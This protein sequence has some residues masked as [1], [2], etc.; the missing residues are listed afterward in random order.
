MMSIV[1]TS[2]LESRVAIRRRAWADPPT[3]VIVTYSVPTLLTACR[4]AAA[5]VVPDGR[6]C[7]EQRI[8]G[9]SQRLYSAHE[10]AGKLAVSSLPSFRKRAGVKSGFGD[11]VAPRDLDTDIAKARVFQQCEVDL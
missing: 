11:S 1:C 3:T 6:R 4:R 2:F 8:D 10:C 9:R 7:R 5:A